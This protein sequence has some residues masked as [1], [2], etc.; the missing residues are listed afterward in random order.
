MDKPKETPEQRRERIRLS[1]TMKTKV[2]PDKK[3]YD[4]KRAK[5]NKDWPAFLLEENNHPPKRSTIHV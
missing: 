3:K 5:L 4:R 1:K 2:V